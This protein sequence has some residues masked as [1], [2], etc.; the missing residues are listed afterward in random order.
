MTLFEQIRE[1]PKVDMHIN[2]TSSISTNLAFDLNS[3]SNIIDVIEKMQEKNFMDYENSLKLPIK[4][5]RSGK[6]L[7]LAINDLIDRLIKNNIIYAE[8]FLDLN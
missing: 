1:I 3:D 7:K 6:N 8:L 5:L 4:I 2:L